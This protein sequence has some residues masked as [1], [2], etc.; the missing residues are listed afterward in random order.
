MIN[1][2]VFASIFL[3]LLA[4]FTWAKS[5]APN[6]P[7]FYRQWALDNDGSQ[8]VNIDFDNLHSIEQKAVSG[9]DIGWVKAQALILKSDLQPVIV[10]VID[11]GLDINHPDLV[12]RIAPGAFDFLT[13]SNVMSDPTGHGTEVAGVI[14]A[15]TNN[16]IGIS[17]IAPSSVKVLP[18]RILGR[19]GEYQNFSYKGKL[20]SDYA[21][22]AIRYALEHKASV[23]NM[24]LGWPKLA[25]TSNVRK[26]I[27]EAEAAGVLIVAAAGNDR[28][29]NPSFPCS[30][31]GVMCVGSVSN[32]GAM[33]YY[34]NLGGA[35]DVL[36]PGDDIT[37]TFPMMLESK[38]MRT[39][40]YES[41]RGTSISAPII[42]AVAATLRSINPKM[43]LSELR[44]RIYLSTLDS[45]I[46]AGK[47]KSALFGL[48]NLA[49][50]IDVS[51][52]PILYPH[53]KGVDEVVVDEKTLTAKGKITVEN[54]WASA[55]GVSA[56]I[57]INSK[58]VGQTK[59]QTL[60]P[61][62]SLVIDWQYQFANFEESSIP[63][64]KLQI[65]FNG[66]EVAEFALDLTCVRKVSEIAKQQNLKIPDIEPST[67]LGSSQGLYYSMLRNAP[68]YGDSTSS[69]RYYIV[70]ASNEKGSDIQVFDP[71]SKN[72]V[73][74]I[75][76][77]G[78]QRVFQ[79][80]RIDLRHNGNYSWVIT[81]TKRD[82]TQAYFVFYF[83]N[84][85]FETLNQ[86]LEA[87]TW[88]YQLDPSFGGMVPRDYASPGSWIDRDGLLVPCF[89]A[90]GALPKLDNYD[91]LDARHYQTD[92]HFYYLVPQ[93]QK[94]LRL[95][96]SLEI[97]A[98][99]N[100]KFRS[101]FDAFY[102]QNLV[103][104]SNLDQRQGHIR[105]LIALGTNVDAENVTWD[106]SSVTKKQTVRNP[107]WDVLSA[108][109]QYIRVLSLDMSN[110]VSALNTL[111]DQE[112]GSLAWLNSSGQF[113]GRNEYSFKSLENQMTGQAI[114]GAYN[115]ASLGRIWFVQTRFDLVAFHQGVNESSPDFH[116]MSLDRDS[117]FAT[118]QY[119]SLLTSVI[120]GTQSHPLP[121]LFIDS[122]L[123][124]G[125]LLSIVLL[126]PR[127]LEMKKPLRY[128]L[129]MPEACVQ[130]TT[131]YADTSIDSFSLALL[132]LKNEHLEFRTLQF[133]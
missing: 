114:V 110:E 82:A 16:G 118:Q 95:P 80:I 106:I 26:A 19:D 14:V 101:S 129:Q 13:Q 103:P 77:P 40:G 9:V 75:H 59:A 60:S 17:G 87:S 71:S 73:N 5:T 124:R 37:S 8:S 42:S 62:Q 15:N 98:L 67:W 94:D 12:G 23:I 21:A 31:S 116:V 102:L 107:G 49:K 52:R 24:S 68:T 84:D 25:D 123:V 22:D 104:Q 88:Q 55:S 131:Y 39:Q 100:K 43:P 32:N 130:M 93:V 36:A 108:S 1:R 83:L 64:M 11:S 53:F 120:V 30:Y 29:A 112:T 7:L 97:H 38:V 127:T 89:L 2:T 79:V 20:L 122:T 128:S 90:N 72:A 92:N 56:K 70:S 33:T 105:I 44:A 18:L 117:T 125:D 51:P 109:G 6:D 133:Q 78:I 96:V 41:V 119:Q 27:Q 4:S 57:F 69:P 48:A 121:G 115:L 45:K 113:L 85:R 86:T 111:F 81:G 50:A 58:L 65:S 126:D 3:L 28:K 34:S 46:V 35:V 66:G 76:I 74:K 99:D 47:T 91:G 63:Q 132:C 54:L 61:A 10:A